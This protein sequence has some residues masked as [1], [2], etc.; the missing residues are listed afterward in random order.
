MRLLRRSDELRS[1]GTVV[2][3]CLAADDVGAA[4]AAAAAD[5]ER[6]PSNPEPQSQLAHLAAVR[7]DW[8]AAHD[9][10]LRALTLACEM[11]EIAALPRDLRPVEPMPRARGGLPIVVIYRHLALEPGSADHLPYS[12]AHIRESNPGSPLFLV[13]DGLH[14]SHL[15]ENVALFEFYSSASQFAK[16]YRHKAFPV[17]YDFMLFS[18]Q[19]LFVLRDFMEKAAIDEVLHIDPDVLVCSDV[20]R[21]AERLPDADFAISASPRFAHSPHYLLLRRREPL[22]RFCEFMVDL[23]KNP[24]ARTSLREIVDGKDPAYL[25][26]MHALQEFVALTHASLWNLSAVHEGGV[27]DANVRSSDGFA[28][29]RGMKDLHWRG[30]LPFALHLTSRAWVQFHAVHYNHTA[31]P[32]LI[33]GYHHRRPGCEGPQ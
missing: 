11:P 27:W 30:S 13:G 18:F 14:R 28:C 3:D 8:Q 19:R 25:T 1:L 15:S 9:H 20:T 12:L 2:Q 22:D 4:I 23:F 26:D 24:N 7:G 31:K 16:V 17:R 32:F 29:R 21:L 5:A 6:D 10:N 33:G